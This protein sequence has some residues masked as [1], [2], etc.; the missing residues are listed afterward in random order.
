M[1]E[2]RILDWM[3]QTVHSNGFLNATSLAD[4]FLQAHHINDP[5]DPVFSLSLDA[6]FKVAQEIRDHELCA[7]VA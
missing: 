6:A 4:S 1:N 3:R 2:A 7:T 5:L